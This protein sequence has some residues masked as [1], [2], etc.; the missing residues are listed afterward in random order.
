MRLLKASN[1]AGE[2]HRSAELDADERQIPS[3]LEIGYIPHFEG[4]MFP[5]LYLFTLGGR[6][7]REVRQIA[8][9]MSEWIGPL[10][11]Q[12]LMIQVPDDDIKETKSD[13]SHRE[14]HTRNILSI[15]A[16]LT[17]FSEFNQ[18]P[19]NMYQCQMAKQTMG[20]PC[21]DFQFRPDNKLYRSAVALT[22]RVFCSSLPVPR[23]QTPQSPICRTQRYREYHLDEYPA[24][25]NAVVA[26]ISFTGYDMEDAMILNKASV[27][28]GFAH[29]CIYKTEQ[30]FLTEG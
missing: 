8:S 2:E 20:T 3:D 5:G 25:T 1:G 30:H 16:S 24:G 17:P 9:G 27:D 6:L 7:I 12:H 18:S 13:A 22:V 10:E 14:I 23:L 28:R 26:V 15:L 21:L 29:G 19:R 4:G 11:Q